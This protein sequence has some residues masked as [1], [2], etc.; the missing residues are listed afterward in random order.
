M[1][2]ENK[3]LQSPQNE[4]EPE[5]EPV[6]TA[7][8]MQYFEASEAA[9]EVGREILASRKPK[10]QKQKKPKKEKRVPVQQEP[11]TAPAPEPVEE[12]A[13]Q[14][15]PEATEA[16]GWQPSQRGGTRRG[17]GSRAGPCRT[18][19]IPGIPGAKGPQEAE[20]KR[21]KS[22]PKQGKKAPCQG[23]E[24]KAQGKTPPLW[25]ESFES[26]ERG[27]ATS[28]CSCCGNTMPFAGASVMCTAVSGRVPILWRSLRFKVV[29][30]TEHFADEV[31]FPYR[32][33]HD[34]TAELAAALRDKT[35]EGKAGRREAWRD[36]SRAVARPLN[37]IANFFAPIFGLAILAGA[38]AFFNQFTFALRVEYN[39]ESI[40]YIAQESDF[41]R[42]GMPCWLASSM[43]NIS[44]R[45]IPSPPFFGCCQGKDL[46]DQEELTD[47]IM[48]SSGN[49]L[50]DASG[51]YLEGK[52]LGALEDGNEFLLYM[53]KVLNN[54]RTG[55]EHETVQFTKKYP[56][57]GRRLSR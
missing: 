13:E 26:M 24:C 57:G 47:A 28:V 39:G 51:F 50:V 43:R 56:A 49:E 18:P 53:D 37:R 38:I 45:R 32:I 55:E 23:K 36:Y 52:F 30:R 40:G 15:A 21:R 3:S 31:L 10:K 33:L 1:T 14:P 2:E 27:C 41:T 8:A 48:R 5:A 44:R 6:D 4:P 54:Y 12:P 11:E 29:R 7:A 25:R 16:N 22:R 34:E 17:A 9:A 19:G 20:E 46:P 42:H 35:P